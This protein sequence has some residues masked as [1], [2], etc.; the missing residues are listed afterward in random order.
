[1]RRFYFALC[2]LT[3]TASAPAATTYA[4]LVGGVG[5]APYTRWTSD[6]L[7]RFGSHLTKKAGVPASQVQV[8]TG[9]AATS[10]SILK[11]ISELGSR[12]QPEDQFILLLSGHGENTNTPT[13]AVKGPDLG[14]DQLAEALKTIPAKSQ[15]ILNFSASSGD[16]LKSLAAPNRVNIAATSPS[17]LKQPVFAEFFLRGLES[18]RGGTTLLEAFNWAAEQTPL[19][20]ARWSLTESG[21]WKADGRETVEIFKKLYGDVP[22]RVLDPASDSKKEDALVELRPPNGEVTPAWSNRRAVDEHA[23]IE[24]TGLDIGVA[25]LGD[26]GIQPIAGANEKDPGFLAGK[27]ILGK[28]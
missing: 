7:A 21:K 2:F 19:W 28:P 8:L 15:I 27:T 9:E 23:L 1:M 17:E 25:V 14:A 3:L 13:F 20:I 11:N 6:W 5:Q 24:D 16:F 18:G 10:D 12:M 26:S 4:L 22:N